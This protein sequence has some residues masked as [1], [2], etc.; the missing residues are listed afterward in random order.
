MLIILSVG[1]WSMASSIFLGKLGGNALTTGFTG[2]TPTSPSILVHG[3]SSDGDASQGRC[4]I[5]TRPETAE[6]FK[7]FYQPSLSHIIKTIKL[8]KKTTFFRPRFTEMRKVEIDFIYLLCNIQ[9]KNNILKIA[10]YLF[11]CCIV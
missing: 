8:E 3:L 9:L 6:I 11:S 2:E 1:A 4:M 7:P 5:T 10:K